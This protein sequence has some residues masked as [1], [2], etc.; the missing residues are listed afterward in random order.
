MSDF[1]RETQ[2][3]VK[4]TQMYLFGSRQVPPEITSFTSGD[5]P[6]LYLGLE[7]MGILSPVGNSISKMKEGS[8]TN[9][10]RS[11]TEP[12][13]QPSEHGKISVSPVF[14]G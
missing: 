13:R 2:L 14:G 9:G 7:D 1:N 4:R 11:F 5:E 12:S 10:H 3:E 8:R 6:A